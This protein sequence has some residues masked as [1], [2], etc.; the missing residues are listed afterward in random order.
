MTR[1]GRNAIRRSEKE[2]RRRNREEKRG[3]RVAAGVAA[4]ATVAAVGAG[5]VMADAPA[6]AVTVGG[7]EIEN[8]AGQLGEII[9]QLANN[10][11][12]QELAK[13]LRMELCA[14]GGTSGGADCSMSTGTG[15][16]IVMP[17]RI[18]L[19]PRVDSDTEE[20]ALYKSLQNYF[21]NPPVAPVWASY[22]QT[23]PGWAQ[24][25][26]DLAEYLVA[27]AAYTTAAGIVN[28]VVGIDFP[29]P[30]PPVTSGS[31]KV[32]GDGF[33]F[34]M[35]S[36]GG[37]ATAISFLP[38]SLATA[39]ASGERTA[40]SFALIGM[41][42]AWTTDEIPVT[43]L[44]DNTL[45]PLDLAEIKLPSIPAVRSVS[46]Y[47]GLTGAY[48][49]G[50]GACANIAGT[51]DFRW[52]AVNNE[53]QFGLTDPTGILFDP[54]GVFTQ[55]ITQLL[56][57]QPLTLSKDFARLSIGGDYDL[58]SGN[59][60]RLTSDYGSQDPITI[61]WLGQKITLNPEVEVN[62]VDRPN[63]LGV[64]VITFAALNTGEIVPVV[65]LP[66]YKFPFGISSIGP[67]E[68]PSTTTTTTASPLSLTTTTDDTPS[69]SLLRTTTTTTDDTTEAEPEKVTTLAAPVDTTEDEVTTDKTADTTTT[70]TDNS[71]DNKDQSNNYVGKHRSEN[72]GGYVGKHR[73][74]SKNDNEGSD[75][76][77]SDNKDSSSTK[78]D[79][80]GSSE[81]K[82][83]DNGSSENKG[84]DSSSNSNSSNSSNNGSG[85]ES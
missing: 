67:I 77:G 51:L 79:N 2:A 28:D 73:S 30:G 31:A 52:N 27:A 68:I 32:I 84:S 82:S 16:A 71:T 33:Q 21:N 83:D 12:T 59:F 8:P 7:V 56:N 61:E 10:E 38:L 64:P 72:K 40:V 44:G 1:L 46:C 37:K 65:N 50:V 69:P 25:S 5:Q 58:F 39:G 6:M 11:L 36:G 75:N 14:T 78:S 24:Y 23:V 41:A 60:L 53:L 42:N 17:D 22:P 48:A 74:E 43:I 19:V 34:A 20:D 49:E 4:L 76:K 3:R 47:G 80:K 66:E 18:E 45:T 13:S 70:T 54:T 35:A 62:G 15:I 55:V 81:N 29:I 26:A 85:N 63:H 57:G 9:A